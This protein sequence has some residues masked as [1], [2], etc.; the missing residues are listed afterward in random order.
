MMGFVMSS[1][2]FFKMLLRLRLNNVGDQF[3]NEMSPDRPET[4]LAGL[5]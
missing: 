5:F 1:H 4:I 2:Y 3:V